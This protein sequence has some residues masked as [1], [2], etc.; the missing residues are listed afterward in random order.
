LLSYW[1]NRL[2]SC[3][4]FFSSCVCFI[5]NFFSLAYWYVWQTTWHVES[6]YTGNVVRLIGTWRRAWLL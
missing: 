4:L 5:Q 6:C 2:F 1:D 3:S